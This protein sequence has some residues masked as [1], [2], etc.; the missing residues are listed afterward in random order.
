MIRTK[1]IA[2]LAIIAMVFT[3]LPV[4]MFAAT[5]DSTRLS[6]DDRIG[7]AIEVADAGWTTA[8]TVVLAPA[9]QANLV[10]ALAA[11]PLAGQENAPILL[12]FKGGLS[13]DVKAKII[14]LGAT[15][16]YVVGAIS[17]SVVAEVNAI[18]GVTAEKLS[19]AD[20]WATADAINAK[21]TSPAGSFVVG[22]AATADAL[23]VASYAAAKKFAIVLTKADGTVDASKL[24]G[25]TTYLVGGTTVV[26]DYAGATRL[27]GA[28]RFKT[29]TA[30][31]GGLSFDYARVYVANGLSMVDAL[32]VAPLAAK[33]NAF[34]ALASATNVDAASTVNAKLTTSSMVIAVGGVNAVSAGVV[35]QVSYGTPATFQVESVKV[36]NLKQV[37]ITFS[38]ALDKTSAEDI[39]NYELKENNGTSLLGAGSPKAA[40]Q[41]DGRTVILTAGTSGSGILT[42]IKNNTIEVSSSVKNASKV[43]L[44]STYTNT[45][46]NAVDITAPTAVSV[47][48]DGPKT[49][50]VVFSEPIDLTGLSASDF[51]IDTGSVGIS[52]ALTGSDSG[53]SITL[54]A[55]SNLSAGSHTLDVNVNSNGNFNDYAGIVLVK[56]TL[57]FNVASVTDAPSVKIDTAKPNQIVLKFNRPVKNLNLAEV[58]HGYSSNTSNTPVAVGGDGTYS[59]T[60]R[61]DF[62]AGKYVPAGSTTLYIKNATATS[63]KI[64]DRWENKMPDTNLSVNIVADHT[65]PTVEAVTVENRQEIKV[66][67]SEDVNA[68]DAVDFNLYVFKKSDGTVMKS[69]DFSSLN[70]YGN[71]V[72][73]SVLTYDAAKYTTTIAFNANFPVG[74]YKLTMKDIKDVAPYTANKLVEVTKDFN[75]TNTNSAKLQS[76]VLKGSKIYLTFDKD[77]ATS[78][79][80]SVLTAANYQINKT[81][82]VGGS[83]V[84]LPSG[85]TVALGDNT[86][87]VVITL[88]ST[89]GIVA[90]T[91][92]V[93]AY[94][95][96]ST[97]KAI[98][99]FDNVGTLSAPAGTKIIAGDIQK[100]KLIDKKTVTFEVTQPLTAVAPGEIFLVANAAGALGIAVD[101]A[102]YVN[103][104]LSDGTYGAVVTVKVAGT[105]DGNTLATSATG[106]NLDNKDS[107]ATGTNDIVVLANGL[108]NQYDEWNA[109]LAVANTAHTVKDLAAPYIVS[110]VTGDSNGNGY[111]D[112]MTVTFSEALYAPSVNE[113]DFSVDKY[114]VKAVT[115]VTGA[116]VVL[117]LHE[118]GTPD[119]A[120]KPDVKIVNT[121]QDASPDRNAISSS[122]VVVPTVGAAPVIV[123]ATRTGANAI[124]IVFSQAVYSTAGATGALSADSIQISTLGDGSD[125]V[126]LATITH[127]AG[128]NTATATTT[129][130]VTADT[131][132]I[133]AKTATSVYGATGLP[134][135]VYADGTAS[136]TLV[137]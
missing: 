57:S 58:Y 2:I 93:A 11:A 38:Q 56:Q 18:A 101:S 67:F 103:Q 1:K 117:E 3:L 63:S 119:T 127:T 35:G 52:S 19:G 91:S 100:I 132:S 90:G 70:A 12:T 79:T 65:P 135:A 83:V 113:G 24:V 45:S 122:D 49:L 48:M 27:G 114:S 66:K 37:E 130:P 62:V 77:M 115:S 120:V 28:D 64:E 25:S 5:A 4:S 31:A 137:K 14:A 72:N 71:P 22:Y 13:D 73:P 136:E 9:D 39:A 34:V 41:A 118:K 53:R 17:D 102:S 126:D 29:N 80:G 121:I 69:A 88:G 81:G 55:G 32:S 124:S 75:M 6:G 86:K 30:V 125:L 54:T 8:G 134:M 123:S 133:G 43:A 46:L 51:R 116:V 15:K 105:N 16:V 131:S 61:L 111:L 47:T 23:S 74:D 82:A 68:T 40:L 26:K 84:A 109:D 110:A 60:W 97:G 128:S 104:I 10:D 87:Q 76:S 50:K 21:L 94:V 33:Y 98:S 42:N 106:G 44:G 96:D 78:G 112:R 36:L 95:S 107:S 89:T 108:K 7:T 129:A 59:D 85:S 99:A 92:K 20:R